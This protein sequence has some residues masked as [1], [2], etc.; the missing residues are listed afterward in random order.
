[1]ARAAAVCCCCCLLLLLLLSAAAVCRPCSTAAAP[2][3]CLPAV[4]SLQL[5]GVEKT[6]WTET[7]SHS[8]GNRSYTTTEHHGSAVAFLDVTQPLGGGQRRLEPGQYQWQIAFALPQGVPNSF[9]NH[10]GGD[11]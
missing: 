11:G 5:L 10:S 2:F 8:D 9:A 7:R 6:W 4:P 3:P 1:M